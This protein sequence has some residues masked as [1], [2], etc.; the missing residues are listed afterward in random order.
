MAIRLGFWG[1]YANALLLLLSASSAAFTCCVDLFIKA[2]SI[3]NEWI[4]HFTTTSFTV[5]FP[6]SPIPSG[7][8]KL[9]FV[10]P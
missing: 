1:K 8:M 10:F 7:N 2:G 9:F 4:S 6:P 3:E 5:S